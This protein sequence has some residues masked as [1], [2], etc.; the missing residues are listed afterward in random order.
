M[1]TFF[2][3]LALVALALFVLTLDAER[4]LA[5][6][7][8][9]CS[10]T[11]V[12]QNAERVVFKIRGDGRTD[13]IVQI[14]Y[15]GKAEDFAW[16]LPLAE[17]PK[18][19][20]LATFPQRA[21]TALD[22]QTGVVVNGGFCGFDDAASG[23]GASNAAQ[24]EE[25]HTVDVYVRTQIGNYDV[26]V[27]GSKDAQAT[28]DWLK[29]NDFRISEAMLGFVKLYTAE[30][31]KFLALKLLPDKSANDITPFKLTLAG[32]TP[33]I[34]LRLS[35][36]AA[37]PEMG[38]VVW[39][40]G[41][42]RY[43]PAN[44]EELSIDNKD[45]RLDENYQSNWL[46]LVARAADQ[47][48]GRGFVVENA[49]AISNLQSL[50]MNSFTSAPDQ[51]EA[52]KALTDLFA[53]TTYMTRLYTRLSPEEMTYDPMFKRSTRG[54]VSRFREIESNNNQCGAPP[55]AD[56]CDFVACGALGLCRPIDD[57]G[58][59]AAACACAGGSTARTTFLPNA[60]GTFATT[61]S[62]I[63]KRLSFLNPGDRNEAGAV[64]PDP[65][66]GIDCG[67]H[68]TCVA[69]NMTPT[70]ACEKG[71]VAQ[72]L[73]AADKTRSA[74]CVKPSTAIPDNFYN[75][76]AL[77]RDPSLPIGR[78]ESMPAPTAGSDDD[79][80]VPEGN[81]GARSGGGNSRGCSVSH[82][83]TAQG[84]WRAAL[85]SFA[86]SVFARS[87]RRRRQHA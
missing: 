10:S 15:Q 38:I 83:R 65:C 66:V 41:K 50:L 48:Q 73:L 16:L 30:G 18:E 63:D 45:L 70:C 47:A 76:R 52:Q 86:V 9:F 85:I 80:P 61:V 6:G 58:Q 17:P 3:A 36:V 51:E 62:C 68:G 72:G 77:A 74:R 11:P 14:S 42:T 4:A 24:D 12:D 81:M 54:D 33:S 35:A 32:E 2:Q 43:E 5:C 79:D 55:E 44:S 59:K 56:P 22:A 53:N 60:N 64:L 1:R 25:A 39:I 23:P 26:A 7:G 71:Y 31:M 84:A 37:E 27:I 49:G 57:N 28:A 21:L 20:D 8:F 46:T 82:A 34:P 87:R 40:F 75:R 78:D 13:M 67:G 19:E 69:M 29:E